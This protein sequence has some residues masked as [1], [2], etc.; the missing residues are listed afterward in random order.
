LDQKKPAA[1]V[2]VDLKVKARRSTSAGVNLVLF[3]LAACCG[4][5]FSEIAGLRLDDVVVGV[6]GYLT[7]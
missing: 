2:L 6:T 5:R 7:K 1:R 4:L 3:R